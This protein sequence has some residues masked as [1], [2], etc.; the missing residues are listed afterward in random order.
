MILDIQDDGKGMDPEQ[1]ARSAVHKGFLTEEQAQMLGRSEKM[2][3]VF[4][5]GMSTSDAVTQWS[6]RG[7][8]LDVV[9]ANVEQFGGSIDIDTAPNQG[10]RFRIKLPLTL[11]IIAS[12]LVCVE[13]HRFAIPQVHVEELIRI[14]AHQIK[15]RIEVIGNAEV[16][17]LRG[18]LLPIVRLSDLLGIERTYV[19]PIDNRGKP[20]RR[21][22]IADRRSKRISLEKT[23]L[24][25][26]ENQCLQ[27][28]DVGTFTIPISGNPNP[29]SCSD[30]RRRIS[31][32]L[33][34]L[35]VAAGGMRYGLIVDA[36]DDFEEIV[37]KPLGKHYRTAR[38]FSGATILGDGSIALILDVNQIPLLARLHQIEISSGEAR[39]RQLSFSERSTAAAVIKEDRLH[40]IVFRNASKEAVAVPIHSVRRIL[41][42]KTS[43]IRW[44]AGQPAFSLDGQDLRLISIDET[45]QRLQEHPDEPWV[46]IVFRACGRTLGLMGKGPIDTMLT[47]QRIDGVSFRKPGIIGTIRIHE[48]TILLL[49]LIG[50]V[51][52]RYPEWFVPGSAFQSHPAPE[53]EILLVEDSDF[54]RDH[55]ASILREADYRVL[56]AADGQQGFDLLQEKARDIA[57]VV[58]DIEMPRMNGLE[59]IRLIR[60]DARLRHLPIVALT[61]LANDTDRQRAV[62]AGVNDYQIK[63]DRESLLTSIAEWIQRSVPEQRPMKSLSKTGEQG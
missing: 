59:L 53:Q 24:E 63:L 44:I 16:L 51:K 29:R 7:V 2:R 33:H 34:I 35:V 46:L 54:F 42:C 52:G 31:S 32:T 19:D 23:V 27:Q 6:S 18:D 45:S 8:G 5:A 9:K 3:L 58:T 4:A 48:T 26:A 49:D 22:A 57:L 40:L 30:R 41:R 55:V 12:Q 36:F 20:D 10:T 17:R 47:H 37:V 28:A 56:T 39:L 14:P 61:T 25:D 50:L 38:I 13:G 21:H 62:D 60:R 15:H 11:A 1:I 43:E